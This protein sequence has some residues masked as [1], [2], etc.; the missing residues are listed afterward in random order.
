M[1][2]SASDHEPPRRRPLATALLLYA[3]IAPLVACCPAGALL[4]RTE[5]NFGRTLSTPEAPEQTAVDRVAAEHLRWLLVGLA[6]AWLGGLVLLI[7]QRRHGR[8]RLVRLAGALAAGL[9]AV[10]VAG[11]VVLDQ[12]VD[13]RYDPIQGEPIVTVPPGQPAPGLALLGQAGVGWGWSVRPVAAEFVAA[14]PGLPAPP[15]G[16]DYLVVRFEIERRDGEPS[17]FDAQGFRAS[18]PGVI[19]GTGST[20]QVVGT[21]YL[22]PLAPG[23]GTTVEVAFLVPTDQPAIGIRCYVARTWF[24][25]RFFR[26]TS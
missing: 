17:P 12:A 11:V 25:W 26:P 18:Y 7:W 10:A 4:G 6:A 22:G 19:D 1:A 3:L 13:P 8:G 20:G 5:L 2:S 14:V 23:Q 16:S 24:D 21:P 9:A 15:A